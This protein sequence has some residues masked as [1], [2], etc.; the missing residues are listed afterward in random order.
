MERLA[1]RIQPDLAGLVA[2]LIEDCHGTPV[3]RLLWKVVSALQQQ[4]THATVAQCVGK[5]ATT[6]ACPYDKDVVIVLHVSLLIT[7][8]S[9]QAV[10]GLDKEVLPPHDALIDTEVFALMIDSMLEDTFPARRLIGQECWTA[11]RDQNRV[12]IRSIALGTRRLVSEVSQLEQAAGRNG[13]GRALIGGAGCGSSQSF[14]GTP[15]AGVR[16]M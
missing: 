9:A 4:D 8:E 15:C 5:C 10:Q 13:S 12:C 3:L 16:S 1:C 6:H 14:G 7:S 2:L 11:E